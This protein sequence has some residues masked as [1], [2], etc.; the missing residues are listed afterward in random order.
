[1]TTH[2]GDCTTSLGRGSTRSKARTTQRGPSGWSQEAQK[3]SGLS[4]PF[5][6][7]I[8]LALL[9]SEF[10][11]VDVFAE[12]DFVAEN[13]EEKKKWFDSLSS[14]VERTSF[15]SCAAL[16][17]PVRRRQSSVSYTSKFGLFFYLSISCFF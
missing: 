4:F 12:I 2:L 14:T 10:L 8:S 3:V 16:I 15:M 1:M 17:A 9:F 5:L 11:V 13:P 6:A 7:F